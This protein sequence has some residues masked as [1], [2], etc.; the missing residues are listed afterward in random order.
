[1]VY[2]SA[3][4]VP[5]MIAILSGTSVYAALRF[6]GLTGGTLVVSGLLF[7]ARNDG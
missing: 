1:M 4:I 3:L 5:F 7:S 6:A 2:G